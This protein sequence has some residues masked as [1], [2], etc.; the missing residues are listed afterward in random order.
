MVRPGGVAES[1]RKLPQMI[2]GADGDGALRLPMLGTDR[3]LEAT[4][5]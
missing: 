2:G 5:A 1:L 3:P 4:L